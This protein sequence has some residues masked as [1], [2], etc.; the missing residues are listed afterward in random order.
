MDD[1]S[2]SDLKDDGE[3]QTRGNEQQEHERK[4]PVRERRPRYLREEITRYW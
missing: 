2:E 3:D 1:H 4:N